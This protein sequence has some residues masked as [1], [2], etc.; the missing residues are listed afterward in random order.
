MSDTERNIEALLSEER[1]FEPAGQPSSNAALVT[2]DGIYEGAAADH[3]GFWA[4]QAEQIAWFK[5]LGHGDGLG[6]PLGEVV[7]GREP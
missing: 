3:E 5:T 2:D 7:R 1:V 6:P 4:E